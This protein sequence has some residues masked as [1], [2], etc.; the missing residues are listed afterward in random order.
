MRFAAWTS[1][2][3]RAAQLCQTPAEF[4]AYLRRK[5]DELEAR[6]GWLKRLWAAR[7]Q[8]V[9]HR[10]A[11]QRGLPQRWDKKDDDFALPETLCLFAALPVSPKECRAPPDDWD[12][13]LK[14]L[15]PLWFSPST[16]RTQRAPSFRAAR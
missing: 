11:L 6:F 2:V 9:L 1:I 3:R 16:P 12:A 8:R 5:A 13:P 15:S 7:L 14:P 10:L 4:A